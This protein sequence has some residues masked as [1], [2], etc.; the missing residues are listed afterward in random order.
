MALV[1]FFHLIKT[2][3]IVSIRHILFPEV[4][5]VGILLLFIHPVDEHTADEGYVRRSNTSCGIRVT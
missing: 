4:V 1:C 2:I 3:F 5:M